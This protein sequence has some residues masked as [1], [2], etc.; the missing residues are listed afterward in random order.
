M[1]SGDVLSLC[2]RRGFLWPA[3][4]IY[5]GVGGMYDYGP[6]GTPFK[7]NIIEE[8][9]R[10]Y[11]LGE[12]FIEIDGPTVSPEEVFKASGHVEEFSDALVS[13]R[14]CLAN[15]RADHLLTDHHENPDA[16][17]EEE[18]M[19]LLQEYGIRCPECEGELTQVEQF[20]LMFSTTIGPGSGRTGYLRPETAQ[21]I[22]VNYIPF[23]RFMREKLP[24]GVIQIGRGYRNEISPR[25]GMIRLREFNM[26]E[27][28]LFVD[29]ENKDWP[30]FPRVKDK[31]VRLVPSDGE[32]VEIELEEAVNRGIIAHPTI[33]YFMYFT[34]EFLTSV[35]VDPDRLRFRQ[36]LST[37]MAHYAADCWDAEALLTYGWTELVGIADRGCWD[38]SRHIEYSD[39]DL[40]AFKRY[41]EPKEVERRV[42]KPD[43]GL[44]GPKYK[45]LSAKIGKALEETDPEEA[46][47]DTVTVQVEGKEMH[48]DS[49]YYQ[50]VT[51]REKVSGE[52]VIPHVIE[53][54]HGLDRIIYTCLEHA[55]SENDDGYMVLRLKP[56][57]APIKVGVFPLMSKDGLDEKAAELDRSLRLSGLPTYYDD[58][59]SVGRRYAR[60]DEIGTP[61]C[62]TVDYETLENGTVTIRDRDTAE[63][64]RVDSWEMPSII[65]ALLCGSSFD[66]LKRKTGA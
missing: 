48:I 22:F 65:N 41:E 12:G 38:L 31:L 42:I 5:G 50:V 30:N 47:G 43:Y 29:P 7:N 58:S 27:A 2:K 28:E 66:E 40:T 23:Y 3:Y 62:I 9:R 17:S 15:Y 1:N 18:M 56:H 13:C 46:Q 45:S 36:H 6:L 57:V 59:G 10:A 61:W 52:K 63:Q 49:R 32:E 54:S 39:S 51:Q 44:L 26:M 24:F 21:G 33:A 11:T 4:E 20:N 16:L 19:A 37:E 64:V 8:W 60:M 55:Y 34:Q 25:Q 53:P 14:S 35:G